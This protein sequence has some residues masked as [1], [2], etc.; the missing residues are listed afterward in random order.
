V[1][2]ANLEYVRRNMQAVTAQQAQLLA[3]LNASGKLSEQ[4]LKIS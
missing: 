4:V 2:E 1:C 3:S